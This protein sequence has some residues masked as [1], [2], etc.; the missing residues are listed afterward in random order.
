VYWKRNKIVGRRD[1]PEY[2]GQFSVR[3]MGERVLGSKLLAISDI[4]LK[5]YQKV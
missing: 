3:V 4:L 1:N 5:K 2:L